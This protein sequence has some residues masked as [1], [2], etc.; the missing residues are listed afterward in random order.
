MIYLGTSSNWSFTRRLLSMTHEFVYQTTVPNTTLL[1]DGEA[2]DLS[3]SDRRTAADLETPSLPTLDYAIYL[4][5]A[6]K[7]HCGQTFH[8]FDEASFMDSLYDFYSDPTHKI[9]EADLWYIHFLIIL[10]FGKAFT[11]QRSQGKKPPGTD[12]FVKAVQLLPNTIVL[13]KRPLMSTELLCCISLY[14]QCLDYR[15]AAHI[16]VSTKHQAP[17][18]CPK[19]S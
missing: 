8:L 17:D 16:Y 9:A 14:L 12:F 3:W 4:I 6:V 15:D 13:E 1:F 19:I 5:N 18:Y 2:Y 7:F 11:T 10:A